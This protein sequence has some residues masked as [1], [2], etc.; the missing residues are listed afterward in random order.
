MAH[1]CS[2]AAT[3]LRNRVYAEYSGTTTRGSL[4]TTSILGTTAHGIVA[5][6][7]ILE[8]RRLVSRLRQIFCGYDAWYCGY[9]DRSHD[10]LLRSDED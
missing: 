5:T 9:D 6:T 3:V 2:L 8:L 10:H 7:N 1:C 4:A